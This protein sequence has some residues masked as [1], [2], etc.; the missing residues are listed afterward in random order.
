MK[1]MHMVK[2]ISEKELAM[3]QRIWTQNEKK[4]NELLNHQQ[5]IDKLFDKID[6][7]KVL[8]GG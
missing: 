3:L 4:I 2:S 1:P 5:E 8:I 6:Q 7:G